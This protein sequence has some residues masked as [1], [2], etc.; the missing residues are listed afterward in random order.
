MKKNLMLFVL[1]IFITIGYATIS[2]VLDIN[3]NFKVA[4]NYEDFKVYIS[5]VEINGQNKS[6]SISADKITLNVSINEGDTIT[7]EV[8]NDSYQYD[9]DISLRCNDEEGIKI[10]QI[11]RLNAQNI[12]KKDVLISKKKELTCWIEIN[13]LERTSV[14]EDNLLKKWFSFENMR[15]KSQDEVFSNSDYFNKLMNNVEAL[16]FLLTNPELVKII[17]E[18]RNYE[19]VLVPKILDHAK[20]SKEQNSKFYKVG[21]P[22]YIYDGGVYYL[23]NSMTYLGPSNSCQTHTNSNTNQGLYFHL[24]GTTSAS[25]SIG[26]HYSDQSINPRGYSKLGLKSYFTTNLPQYDNAS[27]GLYNGS[28]ISERWAASFT[29]HLASIGLALGESEKRMAIPS[30]NSNYRLVISQLVNKYQVNGNYY[31]TTYLRS[32]WLE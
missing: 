2:T 14:A 6:E 17:K 3:G 10:E 24:V 22:C 26:I 25:Q 8:T 30:A 18:D 12:V 19:D 27:I 11:G 20:H 4:F 32:L 23:I 21:L 29:G 31:N 13:K 15:D 7:Y 1:I 9:V 16:D 5:N 28:P